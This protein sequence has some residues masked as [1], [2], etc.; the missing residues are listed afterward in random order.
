MQITS[1]KRAESSTLSAVVCAAAVIVAL[2]YGQ[3][4]IVPVALAVLISFLLTHPVTWL[5]RL[6]IGHT[7][8]VVVVMLIAFSVAGAMI[9]VATNELMQ[10]VIR[11]PEYRD[12]IQAKLDRVQHFGGAGGSSPMAKAAQSIAELGTEFSQSNQTVDAQKNASAARPTR[13]AG[14]KQVQ[15]VPV[16]V[17]KEPTGVF[18]TLG[19]VG[20]S[21][22]RFAATAL[23]VI[24]LT[25]F[26]L[27]NRSSLRNRL[28]RL[29]GDGHI[30]VITNAMDDA[31]KRVS[32]YL[33][34]QGMVNGA[35]GLL[36]GVGL[37]FI[38]VPYAAFWGCAAVFLRFIPYIGTFV[39]GISPFLLSLAVFDG[40]KHPLMTLGLFVIV[41]GIISGII[42]PWLY[43][44][45]TGISSLAILIS[46][47]FWT[48]L[49][50][51]I[52]L[53]ISTPLTVLLVVVGR[54]VPQFEFLYVLLGDEP[55]LPP[56]A[57]YY[58]RLLAMDDDEAREVVEDF[59][60][61]RPLVE[62]YDSLLIPA[63]ALAEKDRHESGL[64]EQHLKF[65][66]R[67]TR[68]L[69]EELG[70]N[71]SQ[72]PSEPSPAA[73]VG[74]ILCIP[75]RDEADELVGLMLVQILRRA[76]YEAESTSIGFVED[77]LQHVK[78]C[79]PDVLFISALP[80]LA[81]TH[82]RSLCRRAHQ[83]CENVT[84]VIGLWG[85][86]VDRK[87]IQQKLGTHCSD[88]VIHSIAEAELQ[89]RLLAGK[90]PEE[91]KSSLEDAEAA[92]STLLSEST[93]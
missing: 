38:G 63:L 9:W 51:P 64:D 76:G 36:L 30:N 81:V 67:S 15:P 14:K 89:L 88:Y 48:L 50:G 3:E 13:S 87:I 54:H 72:S 25:L 23:A 7:A 22:G 35:Y 79:R 46:A 2:Y 28:F 78:D 58:Q 55:V 86:P 52:G 1:S 19:S 29:F 75:A 74:K 83:R 82:A 85:P 71:T 6:K 27:L 70:E 66:Y 60:K 17:V 26:M 4:L 31:A 44:T 65:I 69:L 59:S 61:D 10:I 40:W 45:K 49:W 80:P 8:S 73:P 92:T 93:K 34:T 24:I 21:I 18:G 84:T 11:L 41:E 5:E 90:L 12:N 68:E 37:Y 56:E 42:E 57:H 47:T 91:Q 43:A 20:A 33:I 62:L 53:V 39:A 16:R 77:M 32:R